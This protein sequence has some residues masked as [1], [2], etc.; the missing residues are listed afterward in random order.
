MSFSICIPNYNYEK[1]LG[2]TLDSV[3][4]QSFQNFEIVIADNQSTDR[5]IEIIADKAATNSQIEIRWKINKT[6]LGFA[7][8]LDQV[9]RMAKNPYLIMLSSDDVVKPQALEQ[10]NRIIQSLTPN[11]SFILTSAIDTIDSEGKI[12]KT[13]PAADSYRSI[14]TPK[15]RDEDLSQQMGYSVFKVAG[16][17]LLERLIKTSS[18]PFNFCATC[19]PYQSYELAGGY[20]SSRLMNPDKWFHWRLLAKI[21]FAYFIDEPLFQ[22]RWHAKNQTAQEKNSGHLKFIVDEYRT[23][24]EINNELLN[25]T[26]LDKEDVYKAFIEN[27]ILRHGLAELSKGLW[28]KALRIFMFGWAAYPKIMLQKSQKSIPYFLLLLT[29]PIGILILKMLKRWFVHS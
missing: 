23:S 21:D 12:L 17:E 26:N 22:Y 1:Y 14:W 15:D 25:V 19:F 7:G 9:A 16:N 24:I 4:Y 2:I 18:N 13:T 27:A 6:N 20:G 3:V 8:N 11:T 5:S 28:L 29:G 10:Y